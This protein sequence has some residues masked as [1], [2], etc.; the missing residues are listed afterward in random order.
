MSHSVSRSNKP[1]PR[2]WV[3][4]E[5]GIM[6]ISRSLTGAAAFALFAAIGSGSLSESARSLTI[7][8]YCGGIEPCPALCHTPAEVE[9]SPDDFVSLVSYGQ[10]S[11]AAYGRGARYFF[12][13]RPANP[14]FFGWRPASPHF[15][16][17]RPAN[18]NLAG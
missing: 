7:P 9:G 2:I 15:S 11:R 3:R 17:S 12:G 10:A 5:A 6:G 8:S 13:R 1:T 16:G 14:H 18:P 4:L